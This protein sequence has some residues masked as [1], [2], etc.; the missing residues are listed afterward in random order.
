MRFVSSYQQ[1]YLICI[2]LR[3]FAE[4]VSLKSL[5][6]DTQEQRASSRSGNERL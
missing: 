5:P 6:R 1:F 4:N 2:V 3:E